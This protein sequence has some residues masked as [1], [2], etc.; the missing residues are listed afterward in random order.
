MRSCGNCGHDKYVHR[1]GFCHGQD[2]S[3]SECLCRTYRERPSRAKKA[4]IKRAVFR[5][6]GYAMVAWDKK[7]Q[8]EQNDASCGGQR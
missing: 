3:D 1:N 6:S 2:L 7:V 8:V 4:R 5:G